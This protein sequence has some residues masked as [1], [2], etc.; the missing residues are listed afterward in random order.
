[1]KILLVEPDDRSVAGLNFNGLYTM[2]PMALELI[3]AAVPEHDVRI[4]DLRLDP[5]PIEHYLNEF[6]PAVVGVTGVTAVHDEMNYILS[7]AKVAGAFT[8][9][10]GPHA[11]FAYEDL[12]ADAVVIGEGEASFSE[13]VHTLEL[14]D[15]LLSVPSLVWRDGDRWAT[16]LINQTYDLWPLPRRCFAGDYRYSAFGLDAAMVEAT[17]GCPHRCRFCVTPRLFRGRYRVRPVDEL[18][19]Y[20]STRP[21]PFVMFP[22]PDFMASPRY[23]ASLLDGIRKAGLTKRYMVA[24]RADEVV[25]NPKLLGDLSRAGLCLTFIGFEGYQQNQQDTYQKDSLVEYNEEAVSI[26]DRLNIVAIGT[27]IVEPKWGNSELNDCLKYAKRLG[28]DITLFSVLTPFP[29]TPIAEGRERFVGYE[30]YDV[31]HATTPTTLPYREFQEKFARM[32]KAVFLTKA[33]IKLFWKLFRR[34]LLTVSFIVLL[35]KIWGY[36]ATINRRVKT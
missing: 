16:N 25:Q 20:I 22:D 28:S 13:L 14:G 1:M 21:E 26:L 23:V 35:G 36:I 5:L 24:V 4:V 9:A 10:G 18:V 7:K 32:S 34:K 11:S 27:I 12:G 33:T 29:G 31:L 2:E 15:E 3:A 6:N 19:K 8:V 17:R 30:K